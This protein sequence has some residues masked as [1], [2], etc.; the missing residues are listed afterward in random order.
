M[1]Q[2]AEGLCLRCTWGERKRGMASKVTTPGQSV[3]ANNYS[4]ST[5]S[6][7]S[8][9]ILL[10]YPSLWKVVSTF[11]F[12]CVRKILRKCPWKV[13]RGTRYEGVAGLRD[14]RSA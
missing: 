2:P 14:F 12:L 7:I 9:T 4:M 3:I 11:L 8:G 10:G 13:L 6:A 5:V 1:Q